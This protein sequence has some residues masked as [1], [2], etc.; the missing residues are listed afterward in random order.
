LGVEQ[1][2]R[3]QQHGLRRSVANLS[4]AE[5]RRLDYSLLDYDRP[6]NILLSSIYQ[7]PAFTSSKGLGMLI[8][9][10]QLSAARRVLRAAAAPQRWRRVRALL[11]TC[12]ADQQPR[13]VGVEEIHAGRPDAVLI[14]C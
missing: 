5:T 4:D 10:W 3:H 2:A 13:H 12:S 6:H 7:L 14:P 8:N 11:R 9:E 1:G